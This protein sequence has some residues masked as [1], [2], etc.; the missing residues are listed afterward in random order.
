MRADVVRS[1]GELGGPEVYPSIMRGLSDISI[2]VRRSAA[3][4]AGKQKMVNSIAALDKIL[5]TSDD[6]EFYLN[7]IQ[8]NAGVEGAIRW[9]IR[10]N[11]KTM[12]KCIAPYAA[13][14]SP[15][16]RA[17]AQTAAYYFENTN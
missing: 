14:C 17:F 2:D 1:F 4:A 16:H 13:C 6:A 9:A 8:P 12:T 7:D 15:R 10:N 11:R 3:I 5:K